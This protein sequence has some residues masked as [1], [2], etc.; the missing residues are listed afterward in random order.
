M[1]TRPPRHHRNHQR[2]TAQRGYGAAHQAERRRWSVIIATRGPIPCARGCGT[3][4]HDGDDWDL[5]HTDDRTA[6]TGPECRR[7]NRSTNR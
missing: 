4:I 6:W 1:P 2:T 3:L 7:C 5:G